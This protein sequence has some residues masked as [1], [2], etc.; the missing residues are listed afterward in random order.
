MTDPA[1]IV[2]LL[3]LEPHPEGGH[4]VETYRDVA[5]AG[6]RG[7]ATAIYFLL[8]EGEVSHWHRVRDAVEI[9]LHH[10]GAPL[11]LSIAHGAERKNSTLGGDLAS[12]QRPQAVVPMGACQSARSLGHWSLVSCVVAPAFEFR[13]FELAPPDW[14]PEGG[15]SNRKRDES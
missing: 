11:A 6:A 1:E 3:G 14:R 15:H 8:C 9:W 5:E 13:G 2:A 12:G 4:Y 10:A 7:R